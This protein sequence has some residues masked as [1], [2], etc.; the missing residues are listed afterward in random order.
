MVHDDD[1]ESNLAT[2]TTYYCYAEVALKP[3]ARCTIMRRIL[4]CY[5]IHT[6]CAH[7]SRKLHLNAHLVLLN[8]HCKAYSRADRR[9][10]VLAYC[11]LKPPFGIWCPCFIKKFENRLSPLDHP[12][13]EQIES[14]RWVGALV[15]RHAQRDVQ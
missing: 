11:W 13:T 12:H 14:A 15:V 1:S 3:R 6:K 2:S 9:F 4:T 10:G 5:A 8:D 7:Y